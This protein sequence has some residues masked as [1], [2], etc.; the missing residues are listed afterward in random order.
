M[1]EIYSFK[2]FAAVVENGNFTKAARVLKITPSA[3]S[4]TI[5]KLE[6]EFGFPLFVRS[7]NSM[8]L[9]QNGVRLMPQIYNMI[10]LQDRIVQE[11]QE[12]LGVE[13]G[14]VRVGAF[15]S[16]TMKWLPGIVRSFKE[17]YPG[18][19]IQVTQGKY[20]EVV[21]GV[22]KG[23]LDLG[24]VTSTTEMRSEIIPLYDDPLMCVTAKEYV[25]ENKTYITV[26]EIRNMTILMQAEGLASDTE[27]FL[28]KHKIRLDSK[29]R[30]ADDSSL[31]AMVS[32]GFGISI[33]PKLLFDG[34]KFDGNEMN[35]NLYEISPPEYRTIGLITVR[36][37][38][39]SPAA[40]R[41]RDE[42]IEY[43]RDYKESVQQFPV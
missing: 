43:V 37:P 23:M 26:E 18:L 17:K 20:S 7:R 13:K 16:V 1:A 33:M 30:V 34:N 2:V 9:S 5:S 28:E 6:D 41:L 22:K 21:E 29:I 19:D 42:I 8:E 27:N 12:I 25:P 38:F 4:H 31:V 39:L 10:K 24:F 15:N 40:V 36:E 3:V 35:V 11:K 32:S 14:T